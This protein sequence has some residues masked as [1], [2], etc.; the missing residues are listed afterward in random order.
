MRKK[1]EAI[2]STAGDSL[3]RAA[4]DLRAN[5][6]KLRE[7]FEIAGL[8]FGCRKSGSRTLIRLAVAEKTDCDPSADRRWRRRIENAASIGSRTGGPRT[9][10]PIGL[11]RADRNKAENPLNLLLL[12]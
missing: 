1:R 12:T 9:P 7:R 11:P 6:W 4:R 8:I 3:K 2:A 5:Y 10:H